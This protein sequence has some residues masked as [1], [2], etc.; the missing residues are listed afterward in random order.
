MIS[1]ASI[2]NFEDIFHFIPLILLLNL[3]K[4]VWEYTIVSDNKFVFSNH[5]K[6]MGSENVLGYI[7]VFILIH[8]K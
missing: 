5:K 7:I 4:W 3:N 6:Y 2:F 1:V 8:P